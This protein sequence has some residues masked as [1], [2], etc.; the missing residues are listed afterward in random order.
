MK[1]IKSFYN[2]LKIKLSNDSIDSYHYLGIIYCLTPVFLFIFFTIE[3]FFLGLTIQYTKYIIRMFL[4]SFLGILFFIFSVRLLIFFVKKVFSY[5]KNK[6]YLLCFIL[7]FTILFL[8][9]ATFLWFIIVLADVHNF[10]VFIFNFDTPLIFPYQALE[11]T[12]NIF[13]TI[14]QLMV[15]FISFI[16]LSLLMNSFLPSKLQKKD[17]SQKQKL[18]RIIF[19]LSI[20]VIAIILSIVFSIIDKNNF[21]SISLLTT[22][23]TFLCTPKTILRLF[24]NKKNIEKANIS[25]DVTKSFELIKFC[26]YEFIFSWSIS[27]YIFNPNET[28]N[29]I[30][31]S[32]VIF[33][34]LIIATKVSQ[35]YLINKKNHIFDKWI[36]NENSK[37]NIENTKE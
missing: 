32:F 11:P 8:L 33:F 5:F 2:M 7:F 36:V 16:S 30:I 31:I 12:I 28:Q 4:E 23:F 18:F 35:F 22:L 37:I 25:E 6:Y 24:S 26:Y 27:I 1:K 17:I 10:L 15:L 20:V 19:K 29:R 21:S 13:G 3:M 34:I 9:F 14:L